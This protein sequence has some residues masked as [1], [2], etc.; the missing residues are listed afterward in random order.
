MHAPISST[1]KLKFLG[2]GGQ[3]TTLTLLVE[4]LSE[5]M[6]EILL[7]LVLQKKHAG[8]L[9]A[10]SLGS[11]NMEVL[12]ATIPMGYVEGVRC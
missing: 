9:E 12:D 2:S 7:Q 5:N 6:K 10:R 4:V 11:I 8:G 3:F 1:P